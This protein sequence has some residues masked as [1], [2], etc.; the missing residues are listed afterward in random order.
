MEVASHL[1]SSD[2]VLRVC[3]RMRNDICCYSSN[4]V[5]LHVTYNPAALIINKISYAMTLMHL[6]AMIACY[7]SAYKSHPFTNNRSAYTNL[8]E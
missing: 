1:F 3:S 2:R 7:H 4:D 6:L 8:Y 5:A